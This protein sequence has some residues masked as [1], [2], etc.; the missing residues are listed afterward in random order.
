MGHSNDRRWWI[1][2]LDMFVEATSAGGA[3]GKLKHDMIN[4]FLIKLQRMWILQ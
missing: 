4:I 2:S 1:V 3:A